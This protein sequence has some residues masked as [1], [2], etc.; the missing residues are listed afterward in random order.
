[1]MKLFDMT[2]KFINR[3]RWRA[4]FYDIRDEEKEK[5]EC[6][7]PVN[8][9]GYNIFPSRRSAPKCDRLTPFEDDLWRL[10][11][12]VRFRK[13]RSHYQ[14][15][16][17]RDLDEILKTKKVIVFA[18]KTTNLYGLLP[19]TYRRL[20]RD[21]VTKNYKIA[22]EGTLDH[23]NNDAQSIIVDYKIKGK[24]PKYELSDA[25]ITLKDHKSDFP[26]VTKCRLINP[27]KTHIAKVSKSV[28]DN[29]T[30]TIRKE[31][32]LVQWKNSREVVTWFNGIDNKERKC[33]ISFDIVE[34]YPSIKRSLV[35][36]ALTF[37]KRYIAISDAD[38]RI[39]MHSCQSILSYNGD[40]WQKKS[41]SDLFDIPMGSFHGAEICDL[42]GLHLLS[43]LSHIFE[44][45]SY[46]LYRDDG[47]AVVDWSTPA[48]LDKLRKKAIS[49]MLESG[50][51]ITIDVGITSIDFLD[52]NLDLAND[53]FR[54]FRK[55]NS[56]L[57][58]VHK[59]SNHPQHIKAA[60]P[61]M[62]ENRLNSLSKNQSVFDD[63][64]PDYERALKKSGYHQQLVYETTPAI[65]VKKNRTRR[66][67][68]TFYNPPYCQ[69]TKT[70]IGRL[71]LE[72][73]DKHFD[74][75][76]YYHQIFN[77]ST[78]K[79]SHCCM[80][81]VKKIIQSHNKRILKLD[82]G[83]SGTERKCNCR[84]NTVCPLN[85]ACL[86]ANVVYEATVTTSRS[87]KRYIGST[88]SDFKSRF[89]SHTYSFAHKGEKET[90]L[91]K[92]IWSLKENNTP[93]EMTWSILKHIPGGSR[94]AKTCQTCNEE[95]KAIAMAPKR[96]LLNK[97]SELNSLCPHFKSRYFERIAEEKEKSKK[98]PKAPT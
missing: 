97:R 43:K 53:T 73:I 56:T 22:D 80:P 49:T 92:H 8:D 4:Y 29:I 12:S 55:K 61:K 33:F 25:F 38:V 85:G 64:K 52:V 48:K 83:S 41:E 3:L 32:G 58:Y 96:N 23:I 1:M 98:M 34:F 39:I 54:P 67:R 84:R 7:T 44:L 35:M 10:V 66:K 68:C 46:G 47:L 13:N 17:R 20:A 63:A 30:T 82:T 19:S 24:I 89:N 14:N 78:V 51:K 86:T 15:Q 62:I 65:T 60:L 75:D 28:L 21:N 27:S 16:L 93:H 74:K 79:L 59:S 9:R 81:N 11:K 69:S 37:A 31:T 2:T 36:D 57:S 77:R 40:I 72:L 18:D 94:I 5:D 50:F 70:N 90:E 45:Q 76:S 88:G 42:I 91:S 6:T 95:K 87:T 26:R 71:F